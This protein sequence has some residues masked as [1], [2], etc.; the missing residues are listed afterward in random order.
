MIDIFEN[1][2]GDIHSLVAYMSYPD[3][4]PR[5][6]KIED[7]SHLYK[8][9]RQDAKGIEFSINYGGDFNT[10]ANNKGIPVRKAKE[11]YNNFMNGFPGLKAYQDWR[12][13]DV[14]SKG[15]ILMNPITRHKAFI[16]DMLEIKE[17]EKNL[18][19]PM[20]RAV[21]ETYKSDMSN[22]V[23]QEVRHYFKR[24]SDIEK[25]SINYPI[26]NR[27]AMCF[28]LF[29]IKLFN[30][31]RKNNLLFVVKYCVPA[32]DEANL[33]CPAEI[34]DK[35]A[36]VLTDCMVS[37]GKPFCDKVYLGADVSVADHWIH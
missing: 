19:D 29:S 34:A 10:I 20:Y 4:I 6:T 21:Y 17:V 24:K 22:P 33:E 7:I 35:I 16:P 12:R 32:H 8:S 26:Q 18:Q 37:G 1:G 30:Y 11:I 3:I 25:Q 13:K 15:Y 5:D 14:F 28:K 23:V 31:L 27:G 2:C 36:K 9:V